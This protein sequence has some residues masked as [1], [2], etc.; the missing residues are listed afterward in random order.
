MGYVTRD[1]LNGQSQ[2][3]KRDFGITSD[4]TFDNFLDAIITHAQGAI[5]N[6]CGV[7]SGFFTPNGYSVTDELCNF[8]SSGIIDL[9]LRPVLSIESVEVDQASRG[10]PSN[11]LELSEVD[12]IAELPAGLLHL[13]NYFPSRIVNAIRVSYTAGYASIP[14]AIKNAT[15]ESASNLAHTILQRKL[16]PTT[17][18]DDYTLKL[19][20]PNVLTSEI[21]LSLNK[22]RRHW[23]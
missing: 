1:E 11:W 17:R 23:R 13:V 2:L 9:Q 19:V 3:E 14:D 7:P 15:L 10:S 18:V 4:A 5:E 12:Y 22:Y 16:S 8:I 6:Y 20:T 21:K